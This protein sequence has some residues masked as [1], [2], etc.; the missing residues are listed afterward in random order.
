MRFYDRSADGKPHSHAIFFGGEESI[1]DL[2]EICYSNTLIPDLSEEHTVLFPGMDHKY[3]RPVSDSLHRFYGVQYQ[4]HQDLL[5]LDLISHNLGEIFRQLKIDNNLFLLRSS[6]DEGDN[7]IHN[8][9][10]IDQRLLRR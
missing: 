3:L 10:Q 5:D 9:P 2:V 6:A 8:L 7:F 4:I 1:E